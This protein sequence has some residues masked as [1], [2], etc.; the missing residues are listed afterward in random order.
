MFVEINGQ[1]SVDSLGGWQNQPCKSCPTLSAFLDQT[2]QHRGLYLVRG[3]LFP[4]PVETSWP[5]PHHRMQQA[6]FLC[7][8]IGRAGKCIG[9]C[10]YFLRWVSMFAYRLR[11]TQT[12]TQELYVINTLVAQ[13][14]SF[15]SKSLRKMSLWNTESWPQWQRLHFASRRPQIHAQ[16]LSLDTCGEDLQ[17][18]RAATKGRSKACSTRC[19]KG[20]PQK[21][22]VSWGQPYSLDEV[23]LCVMENE[24]LLEPVNPLLC[25]DLGK[26][27]D[28]HQALARGAVK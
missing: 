2:P 11:S 25:F 14:E 9:L 24:D 13:Q 26:P 21:N 4:D 8:C 27:L 20:L 12:G 28:Y 19:M 3:Q 17:S 15:A 23:G 5:G 1:V 7:P 10:Q 18:R 6:S 22:A 16:E